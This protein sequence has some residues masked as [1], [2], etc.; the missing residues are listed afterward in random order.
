[1]LVVQKTELDQS[2]VLGSFLL[3]GYENK[4]KT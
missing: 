2:S 4:Q 1:M 3:F